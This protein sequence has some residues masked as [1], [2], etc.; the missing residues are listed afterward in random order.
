VLLTTSSKELDGLSEENFTA[1]MLLLT[2]TTVVHLDEGEDAVLPGDITYT[3]CRPFFS[4]VQLF[5]Y[6]TR[7]KIK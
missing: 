7:K 6:S 4:T 3:V 2:V 5:S 1:H